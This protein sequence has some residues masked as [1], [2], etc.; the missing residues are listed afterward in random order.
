MA[1][2]G[3]IVTDDFNPLENLQVSKAEAYLK[4]LLERVGMDVFLR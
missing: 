1:E 4:V 2:G 3:L